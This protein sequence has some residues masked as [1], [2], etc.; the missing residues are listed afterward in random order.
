[1]HCI[2]LLWESQ[3]RRL[4]PNILTLCSAAYCRMGCFRLPRFFCEWLRLC[5]ESFLSHIYSAVSAS[6]IFTPFLCSRAKCA[7]R[8]PKICLYLLVSLLWTFYRILSIVSRKDGKNGSCDAFC[9]CSKLC[10]CIKKTRSNASGLFWWA[11]G[12]SNPGHLD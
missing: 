2:L 4:E 1:M 3:K 8:V 11:I 10:F 12:D 6:G 9:R 5:A 7:G